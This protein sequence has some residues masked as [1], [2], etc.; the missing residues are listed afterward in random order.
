MKRAAR[1]ARWV[2]MIVALVAGTSSPATADDRAAACGV[3][4]EVRA[5]D[6]RCGESLDGRPAAQPS[7]ALEVARGV[8]WAP[9]LASRALF[10]PIL[11]ANEVV[12]THR[13]SG[14]YEAILTSDDG[15]VGVRPVLRY[16]T[17]F[18]PTA[19]A[20]V[21][22]RRF[23]DPVLGVAAS[24]QT[25]GGSALLGDVDLAG[26]SWS[27]LKARFAWNHRSDR[28]FAGIGPNSEADLAAQGRGLARFGSDALTAELRWAR[29]LPWRF[30]VGAHGDVQRLDYWASDV[31]GGPSVAALYGTA[32]ACAVAPTEDCVD[33]VLVPGFATGLRVAHAGATMVWDGRSHERDGGG[34]SLLVD[35]TYAHGLAGDPSRHV[36]TSGE[37]VVA[38]GGLDRV[39]MLRGRAT[40]VRPLGAAPIPFE[41]LAMASGP[42]WMRAFPDGRFR[43]E[44]AVVGSLEYRWYVAARV[45]ASLF[46]DVGT[47][48]GQGF[49]GIRR[50]AWFPDVGVGL[51][52]YNVEGVHWEGTL[53]TG[54]QVAYAPDGGVRVLLAVAGF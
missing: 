33:P 18:L 43:G 14:W 20:R 11:E 25:A 35:A 48:A 7:P 39:L 40:N 30:I 41:E 9:R 34:V 21:F 10:W 5:P 8:L 26:P 31:R 46:S 42:I 38:V 6:P 22:Y 36:A 3:P 29:P 47:V 4:P 52:L 12:E 13:L 28:L 15:K 54:L 45:D 37:L 50:D 17:G 1:R 16:T 51:R 23:A 19:G 49:S 32:P 44:S 27:G 2:T 24:F 53:Q